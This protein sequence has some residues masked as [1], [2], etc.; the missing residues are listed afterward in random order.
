M[1]KRRPDSEGPDPFA[2][3]GVSRLATLEEVT[4]AYR[5]KA[6]AYHPDRHG[7]SPP[8]VRRQAEQRMREVNEAFVT[9]KK[10]AGL[11]STPADTIPSWG[12]APDPNA[13]VEAHR[14]A[15]RASRQHT[16]QARAA[17][18][19]RTQA[20]RSIPSG[21]A[22]PAPKAGRERMVFGLAQAL[23]TNEL[24]CRTCKSVQQLPGGW[25]DRLRDT[26]WACSACGRIILSR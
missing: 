24:T 12:E 18:A 14:R 8:A 20:A 25:Q 6:Q 1:A 26:D 13:A 2:V 11:A 17:Q 5:A 22:K 3:L 15:M 21:L 9:L 19:S 10:G 16:A 4:A 23:I 7:E